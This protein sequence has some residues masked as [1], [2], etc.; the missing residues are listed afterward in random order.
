MD[1]VSILWA[2]V[3]LCII[4][5]VI[6]LVF[7]VLGKLGIVIPD[8]IVTIIWVILVLLAIIFLVQHFFYGG[9]GTTIDMGTHHSRH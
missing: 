1:I 7:W 8:K 6:Y 5:A 2:L 3:S 4:V 9:G